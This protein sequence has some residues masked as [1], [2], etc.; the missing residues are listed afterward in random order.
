MTT[1]NAINNT[2][3]ATYTIGTTTLTKVPVTEIV[4]QVFTATGTYTPTTGM[5]YC[6]IEVLGGGG[7]GGGTPT[8]SGASA[9]AGSGGGSGG[10]SRAV[11]SAATIGSSQAVT[12]GAGGTGVLNA[13]GNPGVASSVGALISANGGSGGIVS[14]AVSAS[15]S[16][17]GAPGATVPAGTFTKFPGNPGFGS[18]IYIGGNGCL[19]GTGGSSFF[20]GGAVNAEAVSS[21]ST[22]ISAVANSGSGGS[23]SAIYA[24]TGTT[25]AGGA[26]GSGIVIVT[27]YVAA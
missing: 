19:S 16:I 13:N 4:T 3:G 18:A 2:L 26:G 25:A 15:G 10:Y 8:A 5:Q 22:G 9:A 7:A 27:E 20:G 23:G 6:L 12:I 24:I 21:Q 1:N 14:G 11:F 17:Q